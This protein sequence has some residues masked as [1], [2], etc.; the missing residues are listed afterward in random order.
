MMLLYSPA[1][2]VVVLLS[3]SAYL[4][5]RSGM[6]A[7]FRRASEEQINLQAK[8]QSLFLKP[9]AAYKPSSSSTTKTTGACVG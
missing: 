2:S 9:C 3:I 1:L 8:E 4:L 6:Y 7:S 5:M